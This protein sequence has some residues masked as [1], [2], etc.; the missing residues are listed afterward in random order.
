MPVNPVAEFEGYGMIMDNG[1][2][3]GFL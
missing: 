2:M 3:R 1:E